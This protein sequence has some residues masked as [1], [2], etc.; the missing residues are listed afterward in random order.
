MLN[1]SVI[2]IILGIMCFLLT[3]GIFIQI[4]TI[5]GMNQ[6]S[7]TKTVVENELR[8]NILKEKEK[9]DNTYS[10]V[11]KLESELEQL[12]DTAASKTTQ[13]QELQEKLDKYNKLL[14]YTELTGQGIIVTLDDGDLPALNQKMATDYIVH[15][16]DIVQVINDLRNAGAEAISVNNQRIVNT[17]AVSCIGNVVKI[18]GEKV[19]APYTISAIG[20]PD[21]LYSAMKIPGGYLDLLNKYGVKVSNEKSNEI[22]VPKYE[23][24]Y[25]FSYMKTVE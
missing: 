4:K 20:H 13:S 21:V 11:E 19:G 8:N 7:V 2:N 1:K 17:S 24:T 12:R 5:N 15:D 9:Y 23:G 3:V 25:N 6:T 22:T 10:K 14:G 16:G 18:N